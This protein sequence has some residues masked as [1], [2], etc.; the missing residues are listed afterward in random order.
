MAIPDIDYHATGQLDTGREGR[1]E[2]MEGGVDPFG[3]PPKRKKNSQRIVPHQC[4]ARFHN[5]EATGRHSDLSDFLPSEASAGHMK[6]RPKTFQEG[7]DGGR[8]RGL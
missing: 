4:T 8:R 3:L 2:Q 5:G 1:L 7:S 6:S